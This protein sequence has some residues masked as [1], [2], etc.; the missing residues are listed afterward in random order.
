M[1]AESRISSGKFYFVKSICKD[2]IIKAFI[3]MGQKINIEG[4]SYT[5]P[6]SL[7]KFI[8]TKF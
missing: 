8:N 6:I 3:F 7:D 5:I 2:N 4:E 1:K